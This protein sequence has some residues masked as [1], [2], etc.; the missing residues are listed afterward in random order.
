M[1]PTQYHLDE[2]R[3]WEDDLLPSS[4]TERNLSVVHAKSVGMERCARCWKWSP[5]CGGDKREYGYR[6]DLL[7]CERCED[8]LRAGFGVFWNSILRDRIKTTSIKPWRWKVY[9]LAG[10]YR[11]ALYAWA[12]GKQFYYRKGEHL[13]K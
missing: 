4:Y 12:K 2:I 10:F 1:K 13:V 11:H 3:P 5:K 8:A 9:K 6:D 7:L